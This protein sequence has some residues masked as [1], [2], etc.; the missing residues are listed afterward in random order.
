MDNNIF[1]K[2]SIDRV[3][4][5][6]QLND[7]IRV[8]NPGIWIVL[9]SVIVLLAGVCVWGIFGRL[10]TTLDTACVAKDGTITVY[11]KESDIGSVAA[12]Q[13]LTVNGTEYEIASIS[14]APVVVNG[15]LGVDEYALH[16]GSLKT[17]EWV[18]TITLSGD[19]PDGTYKAVIVTD[20]VSPMSFVFN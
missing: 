12:G 6:E 5:P 14:A 8:S 7:Y 20:S 16:L 10:E 19:I 15:E 9:I 4:S 11:V 17:G 1:R 2:K 13:R 3:S 18:Y